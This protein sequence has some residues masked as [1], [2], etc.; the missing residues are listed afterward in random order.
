VLEAALHQKHPQLAAA[1]LDW[2]RLETY[3]AAL[4]GRQLLDQNKKS[5][6]RVDQLKHAGSAE[7]HE[8]IRTYLKQTISDIMDFEGTELDTDRSFIELG[9]DSLMAVELQNKVTRELRINVPVIRLLEG[10]TINE[11]ADCI[12][13]ALVKS[14]NDQ[15][16]ESATVQEANGPITSEKARELLTQLDNLSEEETDRLLN[17]T[18]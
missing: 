11:L 17:L 14:S 6:V 1:A 13:E 15:P 7:Q 18:D 3:H 12:Q 9:I 10:A 4:H 2:S 5:S 16:R 8:L